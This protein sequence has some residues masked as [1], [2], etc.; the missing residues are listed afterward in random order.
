MAT[1]ADVPAEILLEVFATSLPQRLD[2]KGREEFQ[3]IRSICSR[4]RSISLSSPVLWSSV[5]V[6][7]RIDDPLYDGGYLTLLNGWF[8]RAGPS[9]PLELEYVDLG[10]TANLMPAKAKAAMSALIQNH[11]HQWRCLSLC[12]DSACMLDITIGLPSSNWTNMQA[13]TLWTFDFVGPHSEKASKSLVS[14]ENIPSLRRLLVHDHAEHEYVRRYGP[15]SLAELQINLDDVFS[16]HHAHLISSYPNLTVLT[17]VIP[18]DHEL[19]L[20][21][22]YKIALPS[23]SSDILLPPHLIHL[24]IQLHSYSSETEDKFLFEFLGRCTSSLNSITLEN[25]PKGGFIARVLPTLLRRP[26]LTNLTLD[27]WPSALDT[28]SSAEDMEES[29]C[30]NLR[31]LT[32]SIAS[33]AMVE[34][35]RMKALADFLLRRENLGLT[36][37][38]RLIV[39]RD[40]DGYHFPYEL[41]EDVRVGDLCVMVP[42]IPLSL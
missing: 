12:V 14:L 22:G 40:S 36:E 9:I 26:G 29:W 30:P 8:S 7:C 32:V 23:I 2:K 24:K 11:Q 20:P 31:N 41:F 16:I 25:R 15:I 3:T 6:L 17:L 13:L 38:E 4:W 19:S 21:P 34:G 28:D 42:L 1:L 39:H 27:L 18:P 5:S 35:K 10:C 33:G 37:L